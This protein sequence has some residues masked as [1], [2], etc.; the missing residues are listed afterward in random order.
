MHRGCST[1]RV[2]DNCCTAHPTFCVSAKNPPLSRLLSLLPSFYSFSQSSVHLI[3]ITLISYWFLIFSPNSSIPLPTVKSPLHQSVTLHTRSPLSYNYNP[4]RHIM[5]IWKSK[6]LHASVPS[7]A[8][9]SVFQI[10]PAVITKLS[11]SGH[12]MI[13]VA[14][15]C[16][17][18]NYLHTQYMHIMKS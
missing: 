18:H 9:C 8:L 4:R 5:Y 1:A 6:I 10:A 17:S 16:L 7:I 2:T 13:Y 14:V 3:H 15:D 12:F 11:H